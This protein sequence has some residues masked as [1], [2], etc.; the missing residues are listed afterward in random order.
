MDSWSEQK[1]EWFSVIHADK[2]LCVYINTTY[3]SPI[4]LKCVPQ[5]VNELCPCNKILIKNTFHV[6]LFGKKPKQY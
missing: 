1:I 2:S 5:H 3:Q 4:L 6:I